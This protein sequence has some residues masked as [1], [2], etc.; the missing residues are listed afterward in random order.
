MHAD[1]SYTR[2]LSLALGNGIMEQRKLVKIMGRIECA[3]MAAARC[4]HAAARSTRQAPS[5]FASQ[6]VLTFT[7]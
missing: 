2:H 1:A 5:S 7:R 6:V 4:T 3:A